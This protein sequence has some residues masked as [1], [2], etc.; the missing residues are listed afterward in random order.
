MEQG[1]AS[2]MYGKGDGNTIKHAYGGA[3]TT[4]KPKKVYT[5]VAK[6]K[7]KKNGK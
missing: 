5:T 1:L 2:M 6:P 7:V 4:P 3:M